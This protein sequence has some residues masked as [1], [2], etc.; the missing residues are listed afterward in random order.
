MW[1][2]VA[3]VVSSVGGPLE[4]VSWMKGRATLASAEKVASRATNW[5]ACCAA[6]GATSEAVAS[7][8]LKKRPRPVEGEARLPK[9]GW[10]V[11]S[12][13]R[14]SAIAALIVGPRPASAVPS[15]SWL[16]WIASRT[17]RWN[18]F[19]T[20][21]M[22]T[23]GG[24]AAFSGRVAPCGRVWLALPGTTCRYLRP[25]ADLERTV[26]RVSAGSGSTLLSSF[27]LTLAVATPSACCTGS[28]DCT[29]PTRIPPTRTS[30]PL[31]SELASGTWTEML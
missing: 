27:R 2:S 11:C 12:S 29:V 8:A 20:W 31:T 15:S 3:I 23:V 6:T 22:S 5:C 4:I 24:C 16:R 25:S 7:S 14:S 19:S 17:G 21:S 26:T 1:G 28:T 10:A 9:T 13:G 30:L 18:M